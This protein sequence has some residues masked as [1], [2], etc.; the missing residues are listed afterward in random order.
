MSE[1]K[2]VYLDILGIQ[3][4]IPHRFPFLLIDRIDTYTDGPN[5]DSWVGRKVVARKNITFNEPYFTGHFP[6]KPVMPGVLQVEAMAQAGA[7]ACIG[8]IGGP[9]Y[10]V[11][12]AKITNA[13]FRRPVVPGDVL[14]IHA[15]I[16]KEKS[17][18]VTVTC[19]AMCDGEVVCEAELVAKV[20]PLVKD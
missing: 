17:G 14:E 1:K 20:F 19:K 3:K 7:V 18:I 6:H 5:K 10:D 8:G 13:R 12:I 2:E 11:L 9:A 16:M 15:E 4:K